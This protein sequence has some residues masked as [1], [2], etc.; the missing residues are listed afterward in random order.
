MAKSLEGLAG[1]LAAQGQPD[2][3][4]RLF[5]AAEALREAITT[6]LPPTDHV[7]YERSVA[8]T[9]AALGK[10]D[11][12]AAWAEGRAMAMQETILYALQEPE[13]LSL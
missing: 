2:R 11:F 5:G 7:G 1:V 13:R 8:A 6:P 9:R 4:A 10:A 12:A 3:A